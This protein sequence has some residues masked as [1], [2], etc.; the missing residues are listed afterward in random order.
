LDQASEQASS[1]ILRTPRFGLSM[2]EVLGQHPAE[3]FFGRP[4]RFILPKLSGSVAEWKNGQA[5][6][7]LALTAQG[8]SIDTITERTSLP[9]ERV[10]QFVKWESEGTAIEKDSEIVA[11]FFGKDFSEDDAQVC[12]FLGCC[13]MLDETTRN[14]SSEI[15]R[16]A[17]TWA[18]LLQHEIESENFK[19][20]VEFVD[21]ER[22]NGKEICPP[23]NRVFNAFQLTPVDKVKCVIIGREPWA[24]PGMAHGLCSSLRG[25]FKEISELPVSLQHVLAELADNVDGFA[26]PVGHCNLESWAE[27]GVLLLNA[28]LTV[29]MNK[30]NSHRDCGWAT[31]TDAAIR[32]V[33]YILQN[34]AKRI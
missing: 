17:P 31:F 33:H 26:V 28:S 19:K 30:P 29:E 4:Y 20:V 16:T 3:K 9:E 10:E 6:I 27:Q 32:Y 25:S 8:V 22:D 1:S 15:S 5:Q 2:R 12:R 21:R 34:G 11:K 23:L 7:V 13:R 24:Q 14:W 18:K